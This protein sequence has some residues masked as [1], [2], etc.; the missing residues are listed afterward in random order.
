MAQ[1]RVPVK[2]RA[3]AKKRAASKKK[4][5]AR[6]MWM[7]RPTSAGAR[8]TERIRK[9][10]LAL[11]EVTERLSHG[12]AT[13]FVQGKRV[14]VMMSDQHHDDRVA[15]TCPAP[16]G[17][18]AVMVANQPHKFYRPPYVGHLGWLGVYLDVPD[19]DWDE[20]ADLL[21]DAYRQVAPAKLLDRLADR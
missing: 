5:A 14:F 21:S 12:E 9:L 3:P 13:W 17:A 8:A 6:P 2:K 19:V 16:E 18:Q 1:K 15:F 10:C 4:P 20:I 11:P 7:M